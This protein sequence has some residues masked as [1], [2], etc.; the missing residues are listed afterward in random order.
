ME[1]LQKVGLELE[2]E[3]GCKLKK[4]IIIC[5]V[6]LF[7]SFLVYGQNIRFIP[8]FLFDSGYSYSGANEDSV[9]YKSLPEN[10]SSHQFYTK[11]DGTLQVLI[12]RTILNLDYTLGWSLNNKIN[13]NIN[14]CWTKFSLGDYTALQIGRYYMNWN[15]GLV[16]NVSDFINNR[17]K[18]NSSAT[19]SGKDGLD[20]NVN[21]PFD[22]V[23]MN[24]NVATLY[25]NDIKDLSVYFLAGAMVY[26]VDMKLKC[27]VYYDKPPATGFAAHSNFGP[28]SVSLD[29][30]MLFN[31]SIKEKY[32]FSDNKWQVR[33]AGQVSYYLPIN[34]NHEMNFLCAYQF[35]SDGL[36][37]DEGKQFL[38]NTANAFGNNMEI[39]KNNSQIIMGNY[40]KNYRQYFC[41]G[42]SYSYKDLLTAGVKINL[43]MEDFSGAVNADCTYNLL[44]VVDLKSSFTVLFGR[45]N[46][47]GWSV[48]Y[49][50]MAGISVSKK[51]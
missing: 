21:L 50:Y 4:R 16:W 18:W 12:P 13:F 14:K 28:V 22:T 40:F 42:V 33:L 10:M 6:V 39:Y 44:H 11:L 23:P 41:G 38:E 5:F 36:T 43:N 48:P 49:N 9:V 15:E 3:L 1:Q 17:Q 46:T 30:A 29:S 7:S 26:P 20:I 37:K 2:L 25:F 24:L 34:K 35:Q 47:E 51:I 45:E 19:V 32:G 8:S 27:A 31:Q